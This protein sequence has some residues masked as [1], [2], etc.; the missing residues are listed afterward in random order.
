V[1]GRAGSDNCTSRRATFDPAFGDD[2]ANEFIDTVCR[3][4]HPM[5]GTRGIGASHARRRAIAQFPIEESRRLAPSRSLSASRPPTI[6]KGKLPSRC[7]NPM[8][9]EWNSGVVRMDSLQHVGSRGN[10]H[11]LSSVRL[12]C[13]CMMGR[14]GQKARHPK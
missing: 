7:W 4:W 8:S 3:V 2:D 13:P 9:F 10:I 14:G 6:W 5:A 12:L 1:L 11:V